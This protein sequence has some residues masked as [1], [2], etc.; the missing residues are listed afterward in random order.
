MC[1]NKPSCFNKVDF[2]TK[3]STKNTK[4]SN[5]QTNIDK[6]YDNRK[7]LF[8]ICGNIIN[9]DKYLFIDILSTYLVDIVNSIDIEINKST[10]NSMI[11]WREKKNPKLLSKF[12]NSDDNINIINRSMN[13]I[14][15]SNYMTIV[16]EISDALTQDNFRKIPE[17]C[18]YL[19]DTI[20]KKCLNDELFIKDYLQFL[21]SFKSVIKTNINDHI[22]NFITEISSLL[23]KNNSLASNTYLSFVKDV[24]NYYNIGI[25]FA[26]L[27]I[28]KSESNLFFDNVKLFNFTESF[29]YEKFMACLNIINN[30]L[31]WLPSDMTDLNGRIYLIFG[32]IEVIGNKLFELMNESDR[33]MFNDILTLIYNVNNIPNK[34]KFKVLDIQDIIKTF[35]KTKKTEQTILKQKLPVNVLDNLLNDITED[36]I[37][38]KYDL[39]LQT[40]PVIEKKIYKPINYSSLKLV[41]MQK[42]VTEPVPA[43]VLDVIPNTEKIILETIKQDVVNQD[44]VKS[45][46][47]NI[48]IIT[49]KSNTSENNNQD[50]LFYKA[51]KNYKNKYKDQNSNICDTDKSD[52]SLQNKKYYKNNKNYNSNTN[53]NTNTNSNMPIANKY[54]NTNNLQRKQND[55]IC[56][57]SFNDDEDDGFIKVERKGKITNNNNSNNSNNTNNSNNS[58][59]SNNTNNSNYDNKKNLKKY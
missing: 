43:N 48:D 42:T 24:S 44:V 12:I 54:T 56:N 27:Y 14:T 53:I 6:F 5:I 32:I 38:I 55:N 50:S 3:L 20:L 18:K 33:N 10:R 16:D 21:V 37:D 45:D 41:Q 47:T 46:S 25:I 29:V 52:N 2:S 13:K 58:N 22:N 9:K 57:K 28:I 39:P 30:F 19:F 40:A 34:I 51:K 7:V 23:Y 17:Y 15:S 31:D 49:Q 11:N 4:I 26:N 8:D 36:E 59:N 1:D 35:E